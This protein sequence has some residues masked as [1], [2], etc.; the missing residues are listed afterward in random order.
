MQGVDPPVVGPA[1]GCL[2]EENLAAYEGAQAVVAA[3]KAEFDAL[4]A[5]RGD[6]REA[7]D[8]SR[9]AVLQPKNIKKDL[10]K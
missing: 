1:A 8:K 10:D 4:L 7:A 5:K 9:D 2:A 3:V 6:A